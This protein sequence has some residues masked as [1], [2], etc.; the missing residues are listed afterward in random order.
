[1]WNWREVA[2][3]QEA[4]LVRLVAVL[5][6]LVGPLDRAS[7]PES[8]RLRVLRLL[9]PAESAT[10][11]LVVAMA[12]VLPAPDVVLPKP[13]PRPPEPNVAALLAARAGKGLPRMQA[14]ML[15]NLRRRAALGQVSLREAR[16]ALAALDG[17]A[18]R[19][20]RPPLFRL[21]DPRKR[22]DRPMRRRCAV[23]PR[24]SFIGVPEP[25][26][27]PPPVPDPQ[28]AVC[29]RRLLRRLEALHGALSDLP[30]CAAR[31]A[32]HEALRSAEH[33]A[34]ARGEDRRARPGPMR[35]GWPPGHRQRPRHAVD[36]A[37]RECH[38]LAWRSLEGFDTS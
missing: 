25:V 3:V 10:R 1:M 2:A 6:A 22:F 8:L 19:R 9:R 31:L 32:R 17:R 7:L 27:A 4:G 28:R 38:A 37:L 21:T 11:R 33:A 14:A 26:V 12:S 24:I 20:P 23:P 15:A 35:P 34:Q 29:A 5:R 13:R 16:A 30:A 18:A 36:H